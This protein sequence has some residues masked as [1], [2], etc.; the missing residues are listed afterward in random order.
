MSCERRSAQ[1]RPAGPP[2]MMTTSASIRGRWIPSMGLRKTIIGSV[3]SFSFQVS[4]SRLGSCLGL[5]TQGFYEAVDHSENF[6]AFL[7][8]LAKCW[9][10]QVR[11]FHVELGH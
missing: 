4:S 8:D 1:A 7:F 6:I 5:R 11:Q 3:S 10:R 2:P 9:L